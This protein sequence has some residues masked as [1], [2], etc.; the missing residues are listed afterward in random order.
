[1]KNL[2]TLVAIL[3]LTILYSVHPCQASTYIYSFELTTDDYPDETTW[4]LAR[5]GTI[6]YSGGPYAQDN[7]LYTEEFCLDSGY[8]YMFTINDEYGDGICCG[9]GDG[10]YVIS[11]E[12]GNPIIEG[13]EFDDLEIREFCIGLTLCELTADAV[14]VNESGPGTLDG[15]ITI[16]AMD[17]T[18]PYEYS[19]DGGTSFQSSG[20]FPGLG[21]GFYSL[22]VRD[23][24]D[25]DH[26]Q[27]VAI[28]VISGIYDLVENGIEVYPNPTDGVFSLKISNQYGQRE[29]LNIEILDATGRRIQSS[30]LTYS[31]GVY[32]G[33]VSLTAYASGTYYV[34][35]LDENIDDLIRIVRE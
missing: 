8:C 9:Y 21:V 30:N 25:C 33:M 12:F 23:D 15:S 17:G 29:N 10:G 14:V 18:P 32:K 5:N 35:L 20:M 28:A 26:T 3:T 19:I 16:T 34:R 27:T 13:G 6:I 2:F 7:T 24:N 31:S 1:M 22:E 4:T 11:D